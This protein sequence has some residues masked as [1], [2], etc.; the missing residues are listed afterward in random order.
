MVRLRPMNGLKMLYA[1]QGSPQL[2]YV[3][4]KRF[5]ILHKQW[6]SL[7]AVHLLI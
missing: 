1:L 5:E 4:V 3:P 7:L 2:K 6:M